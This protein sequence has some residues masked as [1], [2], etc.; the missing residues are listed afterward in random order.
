MIRMQVSTRMAARFRLLIGC[1]YAMT[2]FA[3]NERFWFWLKA[4]RASTLGDESKQ[5]TPNSEHGRYGDDQRRLTQT[6][7]SVVRRR[8]RRCHRPGVG[9]LSRRRQYRWRLA[10][11]EQEKE[12]KPWRNWWVVSFVCVCVFQLRTRLCVLGRR[13]GLKSRRRRSDDRRRFGWRRFS[14]G[15]VSLQPPAIG[16]AE[17]S[18][19]VDFCFIPGTE[20]RSFVQ[21]RLASH[22]LR[23]KLVINHYS[24]SIIKFF[25]LIVVWLHLT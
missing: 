3:A 18:F 8:P 16:R 24:N 11:W 10:D 12:M 13:C 17:P 15:V 14:V 21:D 20:F 22:H 23:S 4:T 19:W 6:A 7:G 1:F 9:H 2:S 25:F 5:M